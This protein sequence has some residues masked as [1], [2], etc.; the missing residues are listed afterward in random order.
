MPL[1]RRPAM[2]LLIASVALCSAAGAQTVTPSKAAYTTSEAIAVTFRDVPLDHVVGGPRY[3]VVVPASAPDRGASVLETRYL[4]S[5]P[6]GTVVFGALKAGTYQIRLMY[7]SAPEKVQARATLT[8]GLPAG[9][10]GPSQAGPGSMA[11]GPQ[12][13]AS[14]GKPPVRPAPK[15]PLPVNPPMGEYAVYQWNG[16]GGF[17]YQ[18]RFSLVDPRRYRVRDNEWG[19]YSYNAANKQLKF[20]T[21]PLK[22]FGGLYYT[23]G[24]NADGP[25]IALNPS[26]VVVNLETRANGAYQFA[27][28]RPQGVK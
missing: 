10:G 18:Y 24:R 15:V 19:T 25:T 14:A 16:G 28:F 5:D 27:F 4:Q 12:Q 13:G 3:L 11:A 26:G 6:S 7:M 22:G 23:A 1:A 8:V 21:G 2:I 9:A 17:A 20:E